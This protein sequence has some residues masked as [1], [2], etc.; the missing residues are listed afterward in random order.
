MPI[1]G[2]EN[3]LVEEIYGPYY[4]S[5]MIRYPDGFHH[6]IIGEEVDGSVA[7]VMCLNSNVYV[8]ELNKNFE[9]TPYH[10]LRKP[11]E[12]DETIQD[13][14]KQTNKLLSLVT[15]SQQNLDDT[16]QAAANRPSM[17]EELMFYET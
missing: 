6:L 1:I 7:G 12:E 13:I 10:G 17:K 4:I 14:V 2:A 9:L 15:E 3:K 11:C 8:D 5:D 16:Q